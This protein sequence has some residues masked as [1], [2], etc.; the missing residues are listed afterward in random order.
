MLAN[1][2]S[3]FAAFFAQVSTPTKKASLNVNGLALEPFSASTMTADKLHGILREAEAGQTR[4][5]FALYRDLCCDDSIVSDF[6]TRKLAV[7]ND[8]MHINNFSEDPLDKAAGDFIRAQWDGLENSLDRLKEL[9]D[10]S[11]YPLVVM[12]KSF[13]PGRRGN[14][15]DLDD[16][17]LVEPQLLHWKNGNLE[18]EQVDDT[19]RNP[20]G[21]Y[22]TPDPSQFIIHRGHLLTAPDCWGGPMRA[23]LF[24]WLFAVG[25]RD[26]WARFMARFGSPFIVAKGEDQ[27]RALLRRALS[28]ATTLFGLVVTPETD[29]EIHATNT[30]QGGDAFASF[31]D[32]AAKRISKLILGQTLTTNTSANGLGQG[33]SGEHGRVRDDLRKWDGLC[34]ARSLRDQLFRQLLTINGIPGNAP[35]VCFGEEDADDGSTVA[36]MLSDLHDAGIEPTDTAL[37]TLSERFGFPVQRITSVAPTTMTKQGLPSIIKQFSA[38]APNLD[39]V[40]R[41]ESARLAQAFRGDFAPIRELILHSASPGECI[42][43]VQKLYPDW[44]PARSS[45]VI[46]EILTVYAAN[47]A[48]K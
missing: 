46:D 41:A 27:D 18:I 6:G 5:L 44:T 2:S 22:L 32:Y 31:Q 3:K 1:L 35:T 38:D 12:Q 45:V 17:S 9:L 34:L 42:I 25:N 48:S 15:Y 47:G 26:F 43:A 33:A 28:A 23:L 30:S 36:K 19:L 13:R 7:L 21:K 29:V 20:N 37:E 24:W 8:G 14:R 16:L 11:L 40:A 10:S 4:R 39:D